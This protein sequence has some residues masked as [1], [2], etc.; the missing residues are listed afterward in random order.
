MEVMM[1]NPM[2]YL[3]V[4]L[5]TLAAIA[6]I[7]VAGLKGFTAWIDLKRTELGTARGPVEPHASTGNRIEIADL[8]ERLRKLEAIAAGVDL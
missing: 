8:K 7:A 6:L 5:T 2:F 4:S 3:T 1:D